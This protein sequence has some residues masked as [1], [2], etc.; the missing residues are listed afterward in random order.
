M[1]SLPLLTIK[2]VFIQSNP[3]EPSVHY[4]N[5]LKIRDC[6]KVDKAGIDRDIKI[7]EENYHLKRKVVSNKSS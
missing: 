5:Y 7:L 1:F 4:I 3:Q 6:E 2:L